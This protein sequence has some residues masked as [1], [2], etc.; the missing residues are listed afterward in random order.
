MDNQQNSIAIELYNNGAEEGDTRCFY[1]L[2]K[3]Y[4]KGK[5]VP[6]DY[7]KAKE[8]YEKASYDLY[9]NAFVRLGNL[10]ERGKGVQQDYKKALKYYILASQ[11]NN[12]KA[13][14]HIAV[15]Y[16]N[17]DNIDFNL[18]EAI[19]YLLKYSNVRFYIERH[20]F[21]EKID[22]FEI[23]SDKYFYSSQNELGL[24]YLLEFNDIEKAE[25]YLLN[26]GLSEYPFGQNNLGLL[27]IFYQ[28]EINNPKKDINYSKKFLLSSS[29]NAFALSDFILGKIDEKENN[30][31]DSIQHYINASENED[32]PL[33]FRNRK[34][35]D[36]RLEISKK[37]IIC[38]TNLKLSL[39]YFTES[40]L[41]K[42][43]KYFVKAFSKISSISNHSFSNLMVMNLTVSD[44]FKQLKKCIFNFPEFNLINQ[45]NLSQETKIK[46]DF[47][48]CQNSSK[49]ND[50]SSIQFDELQKHED[51]FKSKEHQLKI[52]NSE[53][54][55]D[56][57][58][59]DN[60]IDA[61]DIFVIENEE[62]DPIKDIERLFDFIIW[63]GYDFS[64]EIKNIIDIMEEI[65]FSHPY[66]ILF[67]RIF[68]RKPKSYMKEINDLFYAGFE[69]YEKKNC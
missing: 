10:Y 42:S 46:C 54:N 44:L 35:Y 31:K 16:L 58:N 23:R 7:L 32:K 63:K 48:E 56:D 33:C 30:T 27:Y 3:V 53:L 36:K 67:G 1:C 52:K 5:G 11:L 17:G 29:E 9:S 49:Q 26:A 66:P 59:S 12:Q 8:Y 20:D 57:K 13:F 37:F 62:D 55:D 15:L 28:K 34:Y 4:E 41:P 39:Y 60:S 25:K 38:C 65:I 18:P 69:L 47:V 45:P 19:N 50:A 22:Q 68:V 64:N 40:D 2:G 61:N 21:I 14:Y 24:I 43:K 51:S 6:Q